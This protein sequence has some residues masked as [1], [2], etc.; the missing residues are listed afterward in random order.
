MKATEVRVT[1]S[2]KIKASERAQ[3][4]ASQTAYEVLLPFYSEIIDHREFSFALLLNTAN[5]VLGV[6]KI[7]EGGCTGTIM[8]VRTLFQAAILANATGIILSHNHPSGQLQPSQNDLQ[9]TRKMT[10]AG[11]VMDICILD[12]LIVT[13]EGYY[14]FADEGKL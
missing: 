12:H 6:F 10:E 2:P 3:V 9:I 14:S 1:Y 8:D 11:K 7:S 13:S 5:R 4:K